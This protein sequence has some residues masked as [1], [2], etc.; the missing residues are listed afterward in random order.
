MDKGCVVIPSNGVRMGR[1]TVMRWAKTMNSNQATKVGGIATVHQVTT[2]EPEARRATTRPFQSCRGDRMRLY[3]GMS[4]QSIGGASTV[5]LCDPSNLRRGLKSIATGEVQWF[6]DGLSEQSI[7]SWA[8][9]E[10]I[11]SFQDGVRFLVVDK[12]GGEALDGCGVDPALRSCIWKAREDGA[13]TTF[14]VIADPS[15][16][17]KVATLYRLAR[18]SEVLDFKTF[19]HFIRWLDKKDAARL[20]PVWVKSRKAL[21]SKPETSFQNVEGDCVVYSITKYPMLALSAVAVFVELL[22]YGLIRQLVS[23]VE[24]VFYPN[25]EQFSNMINAKTYSSWEG[26]ARKLD[27]LEGRGAGG[28][29]G[30]PPI[31]RCLLLLPDLKRKL[32]E[33]ENRL[34]SSGVPK[35]SVLEEENSDDSSDEEDFADNSDQIENKVRKP[36]HDLIVALRECTSSMVELV[37]ENLYG[38]NNVGMN[39]EFRALV[40]HYISC[41]TT[42]QKASYPEALQFSHY[43]DEKA[44]YLSQDILEE[45]FESCFTYSPKGGSPSFTINEGCESIEEKNISPKNQH[46]IEK[47]TEAAFMNF[48]QNA[49]KRYFSELHHNFGSTAICLSGGSSNAY[50]HLGVVKCLLERNLLPRHFTGASGGALV[51]SYVCTRTD[52]E[53]EEGMNAHNLSRLFVPFADGPL[54]MCSNLINDGSLLN[55][56]RSV[57]RITNLCGTYTFRE[58]FNR[59]GRSFTITVY[60]VDSDGDNHTRCLNYKTTPDVVIYSA[61]M[62][63]AAIPKLLPPMELL[64]KDHK[65]VIKPY[66]ALGKFWRDGAFENE[67]PTEALRHLFN[68]QF[69]IVSQ[70]EPHISLFCFDKRGPLGRQAAKKKRRGWRGGFI[71]S[72]LERLVKLDLRK[73][74]MLIRDFS[75]LPKIMGTDFS[76]LFLGRTHGSCTMIAPTTMH[77]YSNLLSDPDTPSKMSIYM[78]QG[79][80]MLWPKLAMIE[81]RMRVEQALDTLVA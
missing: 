44:S 3:K 14:V 77:G 59:T 53:L 22:A 45:N 62:A 75:L 58:A 65:G 31:E 76:S 47:E 40:G 72:F 43:Q 24:T 81:D 79:L 49:K 56:K 78:E 42:I 46:V 52:K 50:Y 36:E 15:I 80:R 69:T 7:Y 16:V 63:S 73:W 26:N 17:D 13:K 20:Q 67:I 74:L 2:D 35:F 1:K 23:L 38:A 10:I 32:V 12:I 55:Y 70:V 60:N 8:C 25:A 51:G 30:V 19:R 64:Y 9:G 68:V 28:L 29:S 11:R 48:F 6:D 37:C 33:E 5:S 57:K 39:L 71:L 34:A 41:L 54:R 27:E 61:V 21:N 18:S 66:H 4:L